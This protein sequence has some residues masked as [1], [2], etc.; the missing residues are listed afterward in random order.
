M[1]YR[2][3]VALVGRG[4]QGLR[5]AGYDESYVEQYLIDATMLDYDTV[6]A[7]TARW[8]NVQ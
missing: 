3:V 2:S 8:F 4:V 7:T 6:L 5:D 1:D